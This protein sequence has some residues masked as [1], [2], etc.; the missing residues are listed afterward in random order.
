MIAAL[1]CATS[2]GALTM[3]ASA[4]AGSG[5]SGADQV[6]LTGNQALQL[7][8]KL[9]DEGK[10]DEAEAILRQLR[11]SDPDQLD[12]YQIAFLAGMIAQAREHHE[13]AE[14]IFRKILSDKPD[15]IRVR[16]ELAKS[17]FAQRKDQAAAYHFRL[18]LAN[19]LPP[20]TTVAVRQYL[21][22]IQSRKVFHVSFSAG[23]APSTNINN[24]TQDSFIDINGLLLP[25]ND[26]NLQEKSGVG[27]S[28]SI[29]LSALPRI[30]DRWRLETRLR[31]TTRDFSQRQFDDVNVNA[32]AGLRY[33]GRRLATS[34]LLT[35]GQRWFGGEEYSE[36]YGVR[37]TLTTPLSRRTRFKTRASYSEV[38]YAS[39]SGDGPVYSI[40][41]TVTHALDKRTY[42]SGDF[43]YTRVDADIDR[44]SSDQYQIATSFQRELPFGITGEIAPLVYWRKTDG[45]DF[46]GEIREDLAYNL[47]FR[48]TKR[49]WHFR[50]FAPSF[51][52]SY[53]NSTSN[54]DFYSYEQHRVDIGVTRNF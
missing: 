8:Q 25:I 28:S 24:G 13:A 39:G 38:S 48:I 2:L 4:V 22:Q 50:G 31:A 37:L 32:E 12:H 14:E 53:L 44:L 47:S 54:I 18:A 21:A 9:F 42:L 33:Q 5:A 46:L 36:S 26:P 30:T 52:Y 51:G 23:I 40:G 29:A 16:L 7:A 45:P 17:L 1:L 43:E 20:E 15:L 34:V 19:G 35:G 49:D 3:A 6:T 11:T 27:L 10:L 41:T